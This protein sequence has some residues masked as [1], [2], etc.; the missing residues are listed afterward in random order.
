MDIQ[1]DL[2]F[3]ITGVPLSEIPITWADDEPNNLLNNESCLFL[4]PDKNVGDM[5]CLETKPYVCYKNY[6]DEESIGDCGIMDDGM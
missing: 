3:I 4:N 5:D 1:S 6:D 2:F